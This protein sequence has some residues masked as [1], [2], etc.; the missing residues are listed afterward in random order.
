MLPL[1]A[2]PPFPP[3][4][5]GAEVFG[6]TSP[7]PLIRGRLLDADLSPL[8]PIGERARANAANEHRM[9]RVIGRRLLRWKSDAAQ[10]TFS[11]TLPS[12]IAPSACKTTKPPV[13]PGVL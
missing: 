4:A 5:T 10:S 7:P 8:Q 12:A 13:A 6:S 3:G 11:V 9:R 2:G 1:A